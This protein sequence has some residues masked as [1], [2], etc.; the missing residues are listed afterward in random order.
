MWPLP[1]V[2]KEMERPGPRPLMLGKSLDY[3]ASPIPLVEVLWTDLRLEACSFQGYRP[4]KMIKWPQTLTNGEIMI[5]I[6]TSQQNNKQLLNAG[7]FC[8]PF[9]WGDGNPYW[10]GRHLYE[11]VFFPWWTE[12]V[13]KRKQSWFCGYHVWKPWEMGPGFCPGRF[14]CW[15]TCYGATDTALL[16][17]LLNAL[18]MLLLYAVEIIHSIH[19]T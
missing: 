16:A 11:V 17:R 9:F 3:L 15:Q 10:T 5:Q 6:F 8:K 13:R 12:Q 19:Y 18:G 14:R 2:V 7:D 1:A 4:G